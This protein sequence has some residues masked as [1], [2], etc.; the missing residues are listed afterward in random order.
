MS[1]PAFAHP[2]PPI[3]ALADEWADVVRFA[4]ALGLLNLGN[5]NASLAL[6]RPGAA[7]VPVPE[8]VRELLTQVANALARGDAVSVV[9]VNRT[10]TTQQAADLL[11]V[12]RQYLVR[13]LDDGR[14]PHTRTGAHRRVA[15]R[16]LLAFKAH[17]D[18]E[19]GTALDALTALSEE[20][21]GYRELRGDDAP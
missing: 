17:R 14:I 2:A 13:L 1:A 15:L 11:N 5:A 7:P 12:S 10:L 3:A 21:D 6:T 4:D 19:R 18:R 9:P 8:A 16:D 20:L